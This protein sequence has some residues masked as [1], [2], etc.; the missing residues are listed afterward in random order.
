MSV[1]TLNRVLIFGG[2]FLLLQAWYFRDAWV[3]LRGEWIMVQ[4]LACTCPD[5]TVREGQEYLKAHTPDS[6]LDDGLFY[7][8]LFLSENPSTALDPMGYDSYRIKGNIIGKDR[9]SEYD[10]WSPVFKV[11]TWRSVD[12]SLYWVQRGILILQLLILLL[13]AW[14]RNIRLANY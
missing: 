13:L 14:H 4:G 5:V 6:L 1:K 7:P 10:P 2:I 8:E 12:Q 11:D 3:P 9:V